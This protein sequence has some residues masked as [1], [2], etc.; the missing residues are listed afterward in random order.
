MLNRKK[1]GGGTSQCFSLDWKEC[2]RCAFKNGCVNRKYGEGPAAE[3]ASEGEKTSFTM[4]MPP[5][6]LGDLFPEGLVLKQG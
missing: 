6:K 3:E 2:V 1:T 4:E 5:S